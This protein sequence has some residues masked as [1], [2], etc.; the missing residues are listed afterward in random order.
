[1][2][3]L[4]W[5]GAW[6][7]GAALIAIVIVAGSLLPGPVVAVVSVWDKL[8]HAL[9]YGVL[10]LWLCGLVPR[11]GCLRA[12]AAAFALGAVVELLQA[13]LTADRVA[14][15]ADLLANGVGIATAVALAWVGLAGWAQAVERRFG[16][17]FS[18]GPRPGA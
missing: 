16:A 6:L 9:A 15:A 13:V 11:A 5:R 17:A 3:P 14:D 7:L 2:L 18:G 4:A 1:M 12:A 8:E 10:T